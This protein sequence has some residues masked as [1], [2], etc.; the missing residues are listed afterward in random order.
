MK[1]KTWFLRISAG[2]LLVFLLLVAVIAL[3]NTRL[4]TESAMPDAL[5]ASEK[6]HL[7]E[8]YQVRQSL[9]DATWPGWRDASI[10]VVVYNEA[11]AFLVGYDGEPPDG[12]QK[13]P[14]N[15]QRGGPWQVVPGD[16]FE[17]APYYRQP[18]PA[19]GETPQAFTVKVGERWAASLLTKEYMEISFTDQFRE[20]LPA[21][22]API[23][24]Y[25]LVRDIF[26]RGS[27]GYVTALVHES[28]HAYQGTDAPQRMAAAE[29]SVP[30]GEANYPWD[31]A[32][33]EEAWQTELDLLA[34]AMRAQ[35]EGESRALAQQFLA[36]R[37]RRRQAAAL[38]SGLLDYEKQREWLEGLARYV[39]LETWRLAS[40]SET[41]E[42][43]AVLQD[44]ADFDDY[45][46]YRRRWEQEIDQ[47]G[48]MAGD[49]GDGRF[50]YSGLAQAIL[51]DRMA[52]GWKA[53]A[54]QADVFL[55]DLLAEA[56]GTAQE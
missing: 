22:I 20:Q 33:F 49:E 52:P 44:E 17:G 39:E 24:P 53:E 38:S 34:E 35:T 9:G 10:P 50:Y 29:R 2:L 23:V 46:T 12:W 1:L 3:L 30:V 15:L 25:A 26:L 5:S 45:A 40:L 55:E 56:T 16:S 27:E 51:L 41:Y 54:L 21:I 36:Q 48:R 31:D 8:F 32:I 4:P 19:G 42:P 37:A 47:I 13:V 18:L 43:L 14:Q 28:F 11:Y 6:A 7:S